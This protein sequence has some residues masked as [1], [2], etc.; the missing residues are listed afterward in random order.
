MGGGGGR[1]EGGDGGRGTGHDGR[2]RDDLSLVS[3]H[4]S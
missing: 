1:E 4:S 2:K 3:Y